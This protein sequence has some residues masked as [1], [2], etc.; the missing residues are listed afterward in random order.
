[1]RPTTLVRHRDHYGAAGPMP[2]VSASNGSALT[3][4][5]KVCRGLPGKVKIVLVYGLPAGDLWVVV[6]YPDIDSTYEMQ[7]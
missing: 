5:P 1:M 7:I 6:A 3:A 2:S 4:P